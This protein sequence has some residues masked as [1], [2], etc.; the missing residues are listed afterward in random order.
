[1]IKSNMKKLLLGILVLFS[2]DLFS[3]ILV[4]EGNMTFEKEQHL[5]THNLIEGVK[6]KLEV[7]GQMSLNNINMEKDPAF[8]FYHGL[9]NDICWYWNWERVL[10]TNN[11][12]NPSHV[13][14]YEFISSGIKE[15]FAFIDDPYDDNSGQFKFKLYQISKPKSLIAI[16]NSV[17]QKIPEPI[18]NEV[19]V[20]VYDNEETE[21]IVIQ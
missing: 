20:Y 18:C 1:M 17:G 3:Q 4:W 5:Y 14:Y 10:P 16:Y 12:Y 6:Y 7:S 2:Q 9:H 15:H 11:I 19:M 13:Y 8:M 21:K